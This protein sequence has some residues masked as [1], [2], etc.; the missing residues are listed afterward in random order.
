MITRQNPYP[1]E[2]INHE[3]IIINYENP[4]VASSSSAG[5]SHHSYDGHAAMTSRDSDTGSTDS[6][7]PSSLSSNKQPR[8]TS[9]SSV[10]SGSS[11]AS[12]LSDSLRLSALTEERS[13]EDSFNYHHV[14]RVVDELIQT[15]FTY[16]ESLNELIHGY[17]RPLREKSRTLPVLNEEIECVFGNIEQ[18]ERFHRNL[19]AELKRVTST[20]INIA[21]LFIQN[22]DEF[23]MYTFYCTNLS[24]SIDVLAEMMDR[25]DLREFFAKQQNEV[26]GHPLPVSTYLL[27]PFQRILKYPELLKKMSKKMGYNERIEMATNSMSNVANHINEV[28]RQNEDRLYLQDIQALLLNYEGPELSCLGDFCM[29]GVVY[30]GRN[31]RFVLLFHKLFIL[32]KPHHDRLEVKLKIPTDNLIVLEGADRNF[33][34]TPFDDIKNKVSLTAATI[35]E[36]RLW[37]HHL[38]RLMM[39]NHPAPVP[40]AAK[41]KILNAELA[42]RPNRR[43]TRMSSL[44]ILDRDKK[45]RS[46]KGSRSGYMNP[47]SPYRHAQSLPRSAGSSST[48]QGLKVHVANHAN[49]SLPPRAASF[50]QKSRSTGGLEAGNPLKERKISLDNIRGSV[51]VNDEEENSNRESTSSDSSKTETRNSKNSDGSKSSQVSRRLRLQ[52]E[53]TQSINRTPGISYPELSCSS[54][55]LPANLN[56]STQRLE[57]VSIIVQSDSDSEND[58]ERLEIPSDKEDIKS[59]M[60]SSHRVHHSTPRYRQSRGRANLPPETEGLIRPGKVAE[61]LHRFSSTNRGAIRSVYYDSNSDDEV[62]GMNSIDQSDKIKNRT[63]NRTAGSSQL[64]DG[65]DHLSLMLDVTLDDLDYAS[66]DD[67]A[68]SDE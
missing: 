52:N 66:G 2:P 15:E 45:R 56:T 39:E 27:K 7:K 9:F 10:S 63:S 40:T 55:T 34:V 41:S 8:P 46:I 5:Y 35:E 33:Q 54:S 21:D 57:S 29:D 1:T 44:P 42:S 12:Y 48:N 49:L 36:K 58:S 37:C 4:K 62:F 43:L 59:P 16:L 14:D 26:L 20:P 30:H 31:E 28:Q 3:R 67:E 6:G 13:V 22:S 19:L 18:L 61:I 64:E 38:K 50:H 53:P 32:L 11:R 23:K 47:E 17:L 24:M 68:F 51:E 60:T 65:I 25:P